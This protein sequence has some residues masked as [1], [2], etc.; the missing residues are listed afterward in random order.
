MFGRT[1]AVLCLGVFVLWACGQLWPQLRPA[2]TATLYKLTTPLQIFEPRPGGTQP[3]APSA[4]PSPTSSL[5][6]LPSAAATPSPSATGL[7]TAVST[8]KHI[9]TPTPGEAPSETP[10]GIENTPAQTPGAPSETPGASG[11][12]PGTPSETPGGGEESTPT[13]TAI[14]QAAP[15]PTATVANLDGLKTQSALFPNLTFRFATALPSAP[16]QL[17]VYRQ[18]TPRP[19]TVL[20]A[21]N[22]ADLIGLNGKVYQDE[23]TFGKSVY[24]YTDGPNLLY[25]P[26]DSSRFLYQ[27]NF[28]RFLSDDFNPL[29]AEQ[30]ILRAENYLNERGMLAFPYQAQA[31]RAPRRDFVRF[32]EIVDGKPLTF[33]L[34][35]EA[36]EYIDVRLDPQGE[37]RWINYKPH[38][39]ETWGAYPILSAL[40]A[41]NTRLADEGRA[42]RYSFTAPPQARTLRYWRRT[43]P[44]DEAV[45]LY[46]K[47]TRLEA[48]NP[49]DPED[50]SGA[51][52]ILFKN[53]P[54]SGET[55]AFS[56]P[57][58]PD[59]Y[60]VGW[61]EEDSA[62]DVQR[63][64]VESWQNYN[65]S[66]AVELAGSLRWDGEAASLAVG[67][68]IY[69][70][71][72]APT[73]IP[74]NTQVRARGE[75]FE[76]DATRLEWEWIE[77]G[78]A[79]Y[80]AFGD[81]PIN[82][83]NG[84]MSDEMDSFAFDGFSP[85]RFATAGSAVIMLPQNIS[86]QAVIETV[87]LLYA[88]E[89]LGKLE[90]QQWAA[91]LYVQPIWRFRGRLDNGWA[92][93]ID[94]QALS[95]ESLAGSR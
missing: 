30:Q 25:L 35:W 18:P 11:E 92:F 22:A 2:P 80:A 10:P 5:T 59:L 38:D 51:P 34:S 29:T 62:E 26:E 64:N 75:V 58:S 79:S 4:S 6:P 8:L 21:V 66:A 69:A 57:A 73:Q 55:P 3:T 76:E 36:D 87:E 41:W 81:R 82:T 90:A 68:K 63:F 54:L 13:E 61:F 84:L 47:A 94:I 83:L 89:P 49:E 93:T 16:A 46:G 86:G 28:T 52:L 88:A 60:L 74:D 45:E 12:T 37:V 32:N 14:P 95:D 31:I 23:V 48:I 67:S 65:R 56:D 91:R 7:P 27:A 40:E 78:Q 77:S 20:D 71:P 72:N 39:L 85:L 43:Y 17:N 9:A 33:G 70:L 1:F 50:T 19:P 53:W 44:L 42:L 24:A 15:T